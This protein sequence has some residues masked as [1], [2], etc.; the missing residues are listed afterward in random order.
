M[1]IKVEIKIPE[2]VIITADDDGVTIDRKGLRSALN[3]GG[4]GATK[5]PYYA[6]SSVTYKDPGL[7]RGNFGIVT[8]AGGAHNGGAGGLD[9]MFRN[10]AYGRQGAVVFGRKHKDE[11]LK[12][13][14]FIEEKIK[15]AHAQPTNQVDSADEIAKFKKLLDNGTITQEEFDAKKKQ[16][17]GL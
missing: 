13:K 8:N 10:S 3:R 1:M 4:T 9:P 16:L 12:L 14:T 7:T 17:L 5:V 15:S 6:I 11:I 2:H